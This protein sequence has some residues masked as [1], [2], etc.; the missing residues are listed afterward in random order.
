MR[1]RAIKPRFF[2]NIG[3]FCMKTKFINLLKRLSHGKLSIF[4]SMVNRI[5]VFCEYSFFRIKW[6]ITGKRK[7]RPEEIQLVKENVTFIYKSFERQRM[8]KRLYKNIQSYYPGVKVIIADDSSKPLDLKGDHV[9]V[10]QLPF[11]SGLSFGLNRALQKVTTPFVF[12]MDDDELLTPFTKWEKQLKFLIDH[13]EVDLVG[14]LPYS[15]PFIRPLENAVKEYYRQSMRGAPKPLKIPH[16]TPIDDTYIVLGKVPN[17]FMV[18]T[19]QMKKVGYDDNIRMI[20]HNEFF[21]R[22]AGNIVSA[23]AMKSYVIHYH[24][25]FDKYYQQFRADVDG[26]RRYI[27][28]KLSSF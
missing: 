18:R 16:M 23:L 22:V 15:L 20:D 8:A 6:F 27:L 17:I 9:E 19:D 1:I 11:N 21:Y 26:D 25:Q 12:R 28:N 3:V 14:V 2:C 13:P 4:F 10:I 7:P 24:N 5:L